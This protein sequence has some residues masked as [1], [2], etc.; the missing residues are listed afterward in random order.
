M[1]DDSPP[2][3]VY[4]ASASPRR[5]DLLTQMGIPHVLLTPDASEDAEALE[6]AI[7]GESP[8]GYVRRVARLKADAAS[9]RMLVRGLPPAPILTAD[10]TVAIGRRLLG[11]PVDADD[12]R[13]MLRDLSHR[14]HRVLSAVVVTDG[15]RQAEALSQ[16]RVR[17]RR[18]DDADIEAYVASDEPFGKAGGYAI[19]GRAAAFVARISGSHSGIVGLPLFETIALLAEFGIGPA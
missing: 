2:P 18:L 13:A 12:A 19:Q 15:R 6:A 8:R 16:S 17:F 4:L 1:P 3:F 10:T 9:R 11:K 14:T 7:P 5:R